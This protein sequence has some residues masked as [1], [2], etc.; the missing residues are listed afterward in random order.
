MRTLFAVALGV[1]LTA[2]GDGGGDEADAG[3][4]CALDGRGETFIAGMSRV[5]A[6]G[7]TITLIDALPSPPARDD[8]AWTVRVEDPE[9]APAADG[10]LDVLPCMPDHGHGTTLSPR[11]TPNGD[12][13]FSVERINLWMPGLWRTSIMVG[14]P[15]A[16]LSRTCRRPA[17]EVPLDEAVFD[18]C[19]DG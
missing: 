17:S 13:T 12:G 16:D 7:Y 2:C 19:I 15:G 5:G 8:N 10:V 4:N 18:F 1:A 14:A 9:G 11:I 6:G 3:F